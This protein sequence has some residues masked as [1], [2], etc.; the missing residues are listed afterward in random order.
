MTYRRSPARTGLFA[1][2]YLIAVRFGRPAVMDDTDLGMVRPVAGIA[3]T[4]RDSAQL[5]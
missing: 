3:A 1:V 4:G 5:R 2:A